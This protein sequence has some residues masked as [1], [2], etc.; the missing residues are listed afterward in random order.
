M[1]AFLIAIIGTWFVFSSLQAFSQEFHFKT[2]EEIEKERLD[3]LKILKNSLAFSL[4]YGHFS[5]FPFAKTNDNTNNAVKI[6]DYHKLFTLL[7]EYY[8]YEHVAAQLTIGLNAIPKE[9]GINSI[10]SGP[11]GI[12]VN[13][14]GKGGAIL[15]VTLGVKKTFLKGLTRPYISATS[16]FTFIKVGSGTGTGT[17]NGIDKDIDIQS[18]F[19]FCW[20]LGTGVQ[21]R[22]GKVV[23]FDFGVNYY[24][25]PNISPSIGGINSYSG[26]NI[27]GG[28]NFILNPK[29]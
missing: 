16:G 8:P 28:M 14:S 29:H 2:K 21:L 10:S 26:W 23:R 1:K 5:L 4:H 3:K 20:Q 15:P 13:G 7:V 9:K 19:K 6:G 25:T 18:E 22:A 12:Q 24:G 27:F 11:N 17:I